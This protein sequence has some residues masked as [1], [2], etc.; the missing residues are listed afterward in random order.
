MQA[1]VAILDGGSFVLPY[2]AELIGMLAGHGVSVDFYASRTRYNGEL[3]EALAG[4]AGVRLHLA[5]V[6]GTVAPRWR[7]VPAY[8]G[9]LL[10]LWARGRHCTTINLQFSAAWL[11]EL[12][13]L[14]CWRRRLVFTVHNPVPHGFAGLRHP[15]TGWIAALARQL[16]FVSES[17]REDFIRRYGERHRA[18]SQVVPHGLLPPAPGRAPVLYRPSSAAARVPRA[19]VFWGNVQPYKGV[20]VFAALARSD[21]IRRRGLGLEI[22][23]A[24][25][26]S[27]APL[28][29]ELV[30][31]GV[32]VH[33]RFLGTAE[34]QALLERDV[35]FLLP[36]RE[37]SQSGAL[38]TLLQAGRLFACSDVGDLGDF[39]RRFGLDGLLLR[40][41]DAGAV[42]A[43]FDH[44][45]QAPDATRLAFAKA[46][47]ASGWDSAW[48][49][50]TTVYRPAP[51]AR[52]G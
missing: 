4:I 15:P 10:R 40:G 46:Q 32:A 31:L 36:Y 6:S 34:L 38:Y 19:L 44:L 3:F 9:L 12:P 52:P 37:A 45:E 50:A 25:S 43:C 22:H 42:L 49:V 41:R 14:V 17:S 13:F 2:D 27:M 8:A 48:P 20:E 51:T 5:D 16:V 35:L 21:E 33:D 24:W 11:L 39:M 18:R 47:Q 29:D 26:A 30:G 23:G 28:R 7:G 1:S